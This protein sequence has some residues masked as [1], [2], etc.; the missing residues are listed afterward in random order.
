[1]SKLAVF[2]E[3]SMVATYMKAKFPIVLHTVLDMQLPD[4]DIQHPQG[5]S[6]EFALEVDLAL[7]VLAHTFHNEGCFSTSPEM[8]YIIDFK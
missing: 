2:E 8:L 5:W 3:T 1:M 7:D 4:V 6:V